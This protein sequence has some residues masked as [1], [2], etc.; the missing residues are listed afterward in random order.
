MTE[1][2]KI[3]EKSFFTDPGEVFII[4]VMNLSRKMRKDA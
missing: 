4:L 3:K 1:E 2:V